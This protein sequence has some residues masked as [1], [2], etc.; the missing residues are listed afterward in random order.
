MC[1]PMNKNVRA[2]TEQIH[3]HFVKKEIKKVIK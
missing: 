3:R 1:L 2:T